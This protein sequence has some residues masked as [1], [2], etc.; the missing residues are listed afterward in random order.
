VI[1]QSIRKQRILKI[2]LILVL[3]AQ[4][5]HS[6]LIVMKVVIR[7]TIVK[8]PGVRI[9]KGRAISLQGRDPEI[10]LEMTSMVIITSMI[11]IV[12]KRDIQIVIGVEI[13]ILETKLNIINSP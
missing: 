3:K 5:R 12:I 11:K 1:T 10:G 2:T 8:D 13:V 7:I 9:L 6:V 4:R